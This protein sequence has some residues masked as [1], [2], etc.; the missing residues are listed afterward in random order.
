MTIKTIIDEDFSHYK[1]PSMVIAFPSCTFKCEKECGMQVCQNGTLATMPNIEVS[2]KEVIER[3]L[4]NNLTSA[5]VMAGLEPFDSA[6]QMYNFIGFLREVTNDDVVIYTGYTRDEVERIGEGELE[7]GMILNL[8][9]Y[10]GKNNI[11]IKF[12]RYVPN[13][14]KHYDEILGVDLASSNQYSERIC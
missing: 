14:E 11:I 9:K 8:L 13:Q 10:I 4:S 3:Y 2:Y 6:F 5:V 7:K 1:K 12:G